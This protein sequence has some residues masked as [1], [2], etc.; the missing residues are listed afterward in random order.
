M[1]HHTTRFGH[2]CRVSLDAILIQKF[3]DMELSLLVQ[4]LRGPRKHT[5]LSLIL[6]HLRPKLN[7]TRAAKSMASCQL[8]VT[9]ALWSNARIRRGLCRQSRRQNAMERCRR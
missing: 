8:A 4:K 9:V 3:L 5:W 2:V 6:H 1:S 7:R